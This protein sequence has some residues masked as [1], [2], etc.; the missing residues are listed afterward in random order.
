MRG[1]RCAAALLLLLSPG[2]WLAGGR[3]PGEAVPFRLEKMPALRELARAHE[4]RVLIL[5]I[6]VDEERGRLDRFLE[7]EPSPYPLS[8]ASKSFL[9][10]YGF[11]GTLPT[12][13]LVAPDGSIH[14]RYL[15]PRPREVFERDIREL[16][17]S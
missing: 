9:S 15:G 14:A 16:L 8:L 6:S 5:G 4:G 11:T 17:G 13:V 3:G 1:A 2:C 10:D 7:S 12:T